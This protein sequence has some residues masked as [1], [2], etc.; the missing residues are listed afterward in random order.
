MNVPKLRFPEFHD[1]YEIKELSEITN[2]I[3]SGGLSKPLENGKYKVY[4]SVG[5][6]G[7]SKYYD[8]DGEKILVARVGANAGIVNKINENQESI[9]K[10]E[11]NQKERNI[12]HIIFHKW[13]ILFT[14]F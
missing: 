9:S 14:I 6:I 1:D 10:S 11:N 5:I 7:S 3:S 4:G 13:Y 12:S 8:Y 2:G